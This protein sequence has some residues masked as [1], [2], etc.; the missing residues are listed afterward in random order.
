MY[1]RISLLALATF[2]TSA[3]AATAMAADLAPPP[4]PPAPEIRPSVTDW[5]GPYLGAVV[6]G[7]CIDGEYDRVESG[8]GTA[9]PDLRGCGFN[10]GIVGG[11]NYQI[12]NIVLGLEGDVTF[13]GKTAKNIVQQDAITPIWTTTLRPRV[14]FL[15]NNDTLFYV[16]GA[17]AWLRSEWKDTGTGQKVK[18][19][20]T[21]YVIGGGIEH[22]LLENVHLRAEYL[23]QNYNDQSYT[24]NCGTCGVG[25]GAGTVTG[26]TDLGNVHTFRVG[27]TW[28][29][30]VSTW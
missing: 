25:G 18:K 15:A 24:F 28:N 9:D 23:Y 1:K 3:A 22:A 2:M 19:T 12:S 16:T 13:G 29:F 7:T 11:F 17:V 14:G 21:G 10:G 8:G 20:H 27:M 30:P 26:T 4:P 6:G 5:T